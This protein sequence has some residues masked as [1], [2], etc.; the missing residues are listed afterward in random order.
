MKDYKVCILDRN[1]KIA[2]DKMRIKRPWLP[3]VNS[4]GPSSYNTKDYIYSLEVSSFYYIKRYYK[5]IDIDLVPW[6][7]I[8]DKR[9]MSKYDKILIF[10]HGLSDALPF[11]KDNT[12]L[13]L[14]SWADLGNR[15]WPSFQFASFVLDKCKYYEF[16]AKNGILTADTHCVQSVNNLPNLKAFLNERKIDKIFIKPVGGDSGI[17]TSTHE[18]PFHNLKNTLKKRFNDDKWNKL[19]VQKF[20]NFS[21]QNSPEYKCLYVGGKLMYIVQTFRLGFFHGIIFPT[22]DWWPHLKKIDTLSK[23]VLKLFE[24]KLKTDIPYCRIDWGYDKLHKQFFLNEFEHAGGTYGE[25]TVHTL[26][27]VNVKDWNV[28]VALAKAIVKFIRKLTQ[29]KKKNSLASVKQTC[30]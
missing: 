20:M 21:T 24:K 25:D 5:N 28:D 12:K 16:V 6:E 8:V 17:G 26:K 23:K 9:F 27:R 29:D 30:S 22:D 1:P 15:A 18:R 13:Y 7:K 19:V 2:D 4:G 14:Q 3:K 11:W 10:N